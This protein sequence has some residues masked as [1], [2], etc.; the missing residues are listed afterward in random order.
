MRYRQRP[1]VDGLWKT[2]LAPVL[3]G[4]FDRRPHAI[5]SPRNVELAESK[6]L[7]ELF[8]ISTGSTITILF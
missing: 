7:N 5:H 6:T 2:T 3:A 1:I 8:H 4:F